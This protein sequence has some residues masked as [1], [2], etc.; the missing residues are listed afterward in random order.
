[1]EENSTK[2]SER[3]SDLCGELDRAQ[4]EYDHHNAKVREMD[5]LTQDYLHILEFRSDELGDRELAQLAQELSDCRR[6]RRKHKDRCVLLEPRVKFLE[7]EKGH[8]SLGM[9]KQLIGDVRT[10]EESLRDRHYNLKVL[11]EEEWF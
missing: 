8:S 3:I 5:D 10:A 1:M 2:L 9:M 6:E 4:A 11:K 7:K